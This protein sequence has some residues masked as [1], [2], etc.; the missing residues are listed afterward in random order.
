[1]RDL[2]NVIDDSLRLG[3]ESLV[4]ESSDSGIKRHKPLFGTRRYLKPCFSMLLILVFE[5]NELDEQENE[6]EVV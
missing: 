5:P 1:M 3:I 6:L 4:R 2:R